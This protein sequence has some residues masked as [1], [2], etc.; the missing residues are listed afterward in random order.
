MPI[1]LNLDGAIANRLTSKMEFPMQ[2]IEEEPFLRYP[3]PKAS[4]K[5]IWLREID[6]EPD[7]DEC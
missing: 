5:I 3:V 4:T 2:L 1:P 7:V 6:R